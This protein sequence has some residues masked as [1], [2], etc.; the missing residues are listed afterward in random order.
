M[1][2]LAPAARFV[3]QLLAKSNSDEFVPETAML[4][5]NSGA[6]PVLV[7]VTDC[8]SLGVFTVTEPNGM[9]LAERD[10]TGSTPVPVRVIVCGE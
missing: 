6:V 5:I 9:A 1:V 7:N 8:E 4:V 3:G 10:T 2:Q